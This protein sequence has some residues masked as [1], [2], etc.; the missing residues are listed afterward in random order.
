MSTPL[1]SAPA[2]PPPPAK[3]KGQKRRRHRPV[4]RALHAAAR[5]RQEAPAG[6]GSGEAPSTTTPSKS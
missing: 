1:V 3:D 4:V 6:E 2:A 5:L